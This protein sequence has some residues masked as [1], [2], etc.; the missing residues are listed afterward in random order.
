MHLVN[1]AKITLKY[2]PT[3]NVKNLVLLENSLIIFAKEVSQKLT[4]EKQQHG[5]ALV[6]NIKLGDACCT[7]NDLNK[8][9]QFGEE[10]FEKYL[11]D[12]LDLLQKYIEASKTI[13]KP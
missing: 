2:T 8:I 12:L 13:T 9:N 11:T 5:Y 1:E 6:T 4:I 3:V 10:E 7:I